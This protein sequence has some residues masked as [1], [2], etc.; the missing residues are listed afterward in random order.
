MPN[1]VIHFEIRGRDPARLQQ[2]YRD[3]FEWEI[4]VFDSGYALIETESHVHDEAGQTYTGADAFMNEGVTTWEHEGTPVW[5]YTAEP[6]SIRYFQRGIGG[7]IGAPM[8]DGARSVS[9][10]IQ[11]PNL[12]AALARIESLGGTVVRTPVEVAPGVWAA[13][14]AD[15]EGN[16]LG[17]LRTPDE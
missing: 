4:F 17:L 6:G 10:S 5:R 16:V 11:V 8:S 7:G 12:D 1:P 15:P 3:A 13:D 9:F 14:F 2:F